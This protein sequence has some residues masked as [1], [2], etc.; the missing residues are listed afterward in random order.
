MKTH[1]RTDVRD[2]VRNAIAFC[3]E[4]GKEATLAKIAKKDSQFV[5]NGYYTYA[6]DLSG[7]VLAHPVDTDLTGRNLIDLKDPNEKPFVRRIIDTAKTKGYG[8]VDYKW[9]IP[10]SK[11]ELRK[12]VYFE[13]VDGMILCCGFYVSDEDFLTSLFK[14]YDYA[15]P[16]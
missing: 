15:G 8:F 10:N 11:D 13:R 2:I 16:M 12:T 4:A 14:C 9:H 3:G 6:L 5:Q 1:E 7:T